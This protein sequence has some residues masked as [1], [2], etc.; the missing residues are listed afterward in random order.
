MKIYAPI[1]VGELYD[2]LTILRL[3]RHKAECA[4]QKTLIQREISDLERL[5]EGINETASFRRLVEQLAKVN[6]TL[7]DIED[8]VRNRERTGA[9]DGAFVE[10]A[11]SVY[12]H[13]DERAHLKRQIDELSGSEV[14]EQKIYSS[15]VD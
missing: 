11:R 1:S 14:R 10:L 7:W 5:A 15:D 9:F 6:A 3:K 13:N 8:Q 2:R 4:E 12:R